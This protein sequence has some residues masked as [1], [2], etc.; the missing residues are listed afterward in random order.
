MGMLGGRPR[1][2][3]R[4]KPIS[5][6]ELRHSAYEWARPGTLENI[7]FVHNY[8]VNMR[9]VGVLFGGCIR[10]ELPRKDIDVAVVA[11]SGVSYKDVGVDWWM[12]DLS[13]RDYAKNTNGLFVPA[14]DYILALESSGKSSGLITPK[15]Y[16][17]ENKALADFL[18][19]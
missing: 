2:R 6:A 10:G 7:K 19:S 3:V 4:P 16:S 5:R 15:D 1:A 13:R 11:N 17:I 9:I 8:L 14:G 18:D 12:I